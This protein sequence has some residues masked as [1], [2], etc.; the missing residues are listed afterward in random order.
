[1]AELDEA[2]TALS[3]MADAW[4]DGELESLSAELLDDFEQFPGLYETLVTKRN[5]AWVP[6]LEGMLASSGRRLVVV[7]ALHLVGRDNVIELLRARGH[8][9]VRV[10]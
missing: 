3:A 10:H 2:E 5:Q 1:L 9:V 7:G 6:K 8:E 4:R